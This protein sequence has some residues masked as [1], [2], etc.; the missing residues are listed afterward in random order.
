MEQDLIFE[1]RDEQSDRLTFTQSVVSGLDAVYQPIFGAGRAAMEQA[2]TSFVAG[3]TAANGYLQNGL[4]TIQT[5][6]SAGTDVVKRLY[7][8]QLNESYEVVT[9]ARDWVLDVVEAEVSILKDSQLIRRI[10]EYIPSGSSAEPLPAPPGFTEV[11]GGVT[12]GGQAFSHY[13][14]PSGENRLW[15]HA[16]NFNYIF[17]E[18]PEWCIPIHN[19]GMVSP[20]PDFSS[21]YLEEADIGKFVWYH[22]DENTP[23]SYENEGLQDGSPYTF[24]WHTNTTGSGTVITYVDLLPIDLGYGIGPGEG[25]RHRYQRGGGRSRGVVI[26]SLFGP[27]PGFLGIKTFD[28]LSPI[29][30]L[31][32]F[33]G[34]NE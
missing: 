3:S 34:D 20:P 10:L 31:W 21:Y 26:P 7:T 9:L 1:L 32:D 6:L 18:V 25:W 15:Y 28:L 14:Q 2:A 8:R 5:N 27:L 4:N 24:D 16:W 22:D 12:I 29:S 33:L 19:D 23:L 17:I 30:K 11:P 13:V